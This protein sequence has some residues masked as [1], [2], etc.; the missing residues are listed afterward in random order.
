M[1]VRGVLAT[2]CAGLTAIFAG[3]SGEPERR[4]PAGVPRRRQGHAHPHTERAAAARESAADLAVRLQA[5]L[6]RHSIW[7]LRSQRGKLFA[8]HAVL[9]EEV[10]RTATADSADFDAAAG[11]INGNTRDLAAAVDT[12]FGPEVAKQVQALWA[13][14][15][16]QLVAY[17]VATADGD[18]SAR[19]QA[20]SW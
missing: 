6:G 11:M 1:R 18:E 4:V 14:H 16:E 12:L 7:R 3:G 5:Q 10:T 8:E 13:A 20:R 9:I 17:A 2:P 15:V 19:Q